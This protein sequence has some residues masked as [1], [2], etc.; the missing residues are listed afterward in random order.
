[1]KL[2]KIIRLI[3][4]LDRIILWSAEDIEMAERAGDE[5]E[6]I[7]DGYI[8]DMPWYL[9]DFKI[10][11]PAGDD[12]PPIY[13]SNVDHKIGDYEEAAIVI[14]ILPPDWED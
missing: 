7:Y 6:P 1:M 8:M 14:N 12:E 10:G 5:P 11:R 3:D 13:V 2:E 9:L 4:P